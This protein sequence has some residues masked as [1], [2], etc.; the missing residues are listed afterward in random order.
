MIERLGPGENYWIVTRDDFNPDRPIG[1]I[2]DHIQG[3][4]WGIEDDTLASEIVAHLLRLGAERV[5]INE[6]RERRVALGR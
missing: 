3:I 4:T 6:F 1:L 2:Y 5:S